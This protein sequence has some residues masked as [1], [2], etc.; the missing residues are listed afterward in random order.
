MKHIKAA[1]QIESVCQKYLVKKQYL[2]E[3]EGKLKRN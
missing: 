2:K 1:K 3:K